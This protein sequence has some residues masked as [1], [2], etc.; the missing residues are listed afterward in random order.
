MILSDLHVHTVYCDGKSTVDETVKAAL[1]KNMESVGFSSHEYTAFDTSYCMS[2]RKTS[3]YTREVQN[4][5]QKYKGKIDI[6][7]G[8]ERDLYCEK[9]AEYDYVIGSA[10]YI[11]KDG[12]YI[13]VDE[14]AEITENAVKEHFGGSFLK[15]IRSYFETAAQIPQKTHADI[16]GHFDLVCK[17]NDKNRY[18]DENSKEY[19]NTALEALKAAAEKC[20]IL[21]MNTGAVS[22]GCRTDAYPADFIL[23]GAKEFG[24]KII[25]SSDSHDCK[26]LCFGFD[27]CTNRLKQNGFKSVVVLRNG[28]FTEVGI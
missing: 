5:K 20:E 13:P 11:K 9:D 18:F 16:I 24:M 7:L 25:L 17:F 4:A 2:R 8:I 27:E 12:V 1:D 19:K 26:N 21:E 14:S 23:A 22:R 6:Y 15:Y 10:H 3:E 28:E